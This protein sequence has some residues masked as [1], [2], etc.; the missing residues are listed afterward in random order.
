MPPPSSTRPP[1]T[2]TSATSCSRSPRASPTRTAARETF[3]Q[4]VEQY[5][6]VLKVQPNSIEAVNNKAWILHTYLGRVQEALELVRRPAEARRRRRR[7]PASSSTP[8]VRSRNRSA[9]PRDAE[10]SYLDGLKKDPENP[11]LNFHFGKLIAADRSRAAKAKS[12]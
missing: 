11:V 5:D 12:T 6:L 2:S 3:E 7:C 10:Q 8:W 4:A 1:P 9:R